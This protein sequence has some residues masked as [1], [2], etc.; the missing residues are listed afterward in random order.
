MELSEFLF[1]RVSLVRFYF[2]CFKLGALHQSDLIDV[3][4]YCVG[5]RKTQVTFSVEFEDSNPCNWRLGSCFD[6]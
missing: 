5:S 6:P 2:V 3:S 1:S 4:E